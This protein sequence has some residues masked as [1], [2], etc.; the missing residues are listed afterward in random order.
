MQKI[1][2]SAELAAIIACEK[3]AYRENTA[4]ICPNRHGSDAAIAGKSHFFSRS[5]LPDWRMKPDVRPRFK[6]RFKAGAADAH[7]G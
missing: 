3:Q 1:V 5:M 2:W 7:H 6:G 4:V